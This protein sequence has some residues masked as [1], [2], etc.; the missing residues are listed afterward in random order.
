MSNCNKTSVITKSV[1]LMQ[2]KQKIVD[3]DF[4]ECKLKQH[5]PPSVVSN[6]NIIQHNPFKTVHLSPNSPEAYYMMPS[7]PEN[8]LF[9][10]YDLYKYDSLK[11]K[12]KPIPVPI[13]NK[14]D[15]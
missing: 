13:E 2:T 7:S 9:S 8:T 3:T 4:D 1:N 15:A 10:Y 14:D 5:R 6:C 11:C 12:R